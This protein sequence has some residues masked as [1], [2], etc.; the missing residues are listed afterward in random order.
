[1]NDVMTIRWEDLAACYG[2]QID[3]Y[4]GELDSNR[5]STHAVLCIPLP[6]G[7]AKFKSEDG[8]HA[9]ER[10]LFSDLW[11]S[12]VREAL[13][14]GSVDHKVIITIAINRAPCGHC[15][16]ILAEKLKELQFNHAARSPNSVFLLA[17]RG[18]YHAITKFD[19]ARGEAAKAG[20]GQIRDENGNYPDA[21][22]KHISTGRGLDQMVKS[23]W[24]LRVLQFGET[25]PPSGDDLSAYLRNQRTRNLGSG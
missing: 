9:E 7:G 14:Y 20:G 13:S 22:R 25:L 3:R 4:K 19:K 23:G 10:L 24:H 1:M 6:G 16:L 17:A 8:E 5:P 18:N 15:A 2:P 21:V 12:K 11:K